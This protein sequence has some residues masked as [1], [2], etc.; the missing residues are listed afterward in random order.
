MAKPNARITRK[1]NPYYRNGSYW[2][3][4]GAF[5]KVQEEI[6]NKKNTENK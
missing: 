4:K 3:N 2:P 5:K 1:K 6:K